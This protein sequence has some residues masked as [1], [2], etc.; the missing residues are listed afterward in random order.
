MI[1]AESDAHIFLLPPAFKVR[2]FDKGI[3]LLSEVSGIETHILLGCLVGKL[4]A[5]GIH[6]CHALLDFIYLSQYR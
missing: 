4:P 2:D 5:K 1:E 6:A 3:S